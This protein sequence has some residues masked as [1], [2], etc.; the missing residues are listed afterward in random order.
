MPLGGFLPETEREGGREGGRE[1]VWPM[2]VPWRSGSYHVT[3]GRRRSRR[4]WKRR[5]GGGVGVRLKAVISYTERERK[6]AAGASV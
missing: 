6:G 4:K 5:M 1:R 3:D 2:S